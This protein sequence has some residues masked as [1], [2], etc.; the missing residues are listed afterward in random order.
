MDYGL[1]VYKND[2]NTSEFYVVEDYVSENYVVF[3]SDSDGAG[4]L[5]FSTASVAWMYV[6][7]IYFN[8]GDNATITR[9]FPEY[10]GWL[11]TT[12]VML[13]QAPPDNQEHYSPRVT[14]TGN[15]VVVDRQPNPLNPNV[16]LAAYNAYIYVM[17]RN[18]TN[19]LVVGTFP[20]DEETSNTGVP[21]TVLA[22][23]RSDWNGLDAAVFIDANH[24]EAWGLQNA[25]IYESWA[26]L[27]R[28]LSALTGVIAT[29]ELLQFGDDRGSG[30]YF[31]MFRMGVNITVD[32]GITLTFRGN[33]QTATLSGETGKLYVTWA[34]VTYPGDTVGS[35]YLA[36]DNGTTVL[37]SQLASSTSNTWSMSG[38]APVLDAS[39]VTIVATTNGGSGGSPSD[40]TD[41]PY[42][43][44][45]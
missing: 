13:P 5:I 15:Q 2:G 6:D 32:S 37:A 38:I 18:T 36:L 14:V 23:L 26:H 1:A 17:A 16:P 9:T 11:L 28:S 44:E 20:P 10:D 25:Q 22:N 19:P 7:T 39:G 43:Q 21:T 3:D 34:G 33:G 12:Q 42:Y 45:H 41:D 40:G 30:A 29:E 27:A 31:H 24:T 35:G 8:A 4:Q